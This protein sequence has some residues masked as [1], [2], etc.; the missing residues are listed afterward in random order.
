MKTDRWTQWILALLCAVMALGLVGCDDDDDKSPPANI[1]GN[2]AC[3]FVNQD[4]AS[5]VLE[6][7]W[8]FVQS[9]DRVS[10]SY[11]FGT[12]V[13]RFDGTYVDGVFSAVDNDSWTLSLEFDGN[14]AFGTITGDGMIYTADLTRL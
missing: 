10:G 6:E 4:D 3:T 5:D 8:T 13:W 14:S 12:N 9:N 11:T 7:T 2:W 1:S